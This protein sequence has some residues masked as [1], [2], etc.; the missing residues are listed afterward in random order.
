MA[1]LRLSGSWIVIAQSSGQ[2]DARGQFSEVE[3][4]P[5]SRLLG[6]TSGASVGT[7]SIV[8]GIPGEARDQQEAPDQ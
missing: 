5:D 7:T 8:I 1:S 2:G 3:L 4:K 6:W